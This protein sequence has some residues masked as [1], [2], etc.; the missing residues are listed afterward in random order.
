MDVFTYDKS[1][2]Y[3]FTQRDLN[4]HQRRW[5]ELLNDYDI[6]VH[7]HPGK[8][9]II[10]DAW[11]SMSMESTTNVDDEKKELSKDVHRLARLDVQLV[12]CTSVGVSVH[13]KE[14]QHLDPVLMEL[15][16]LVLIKMNESFALGGDSILRYQERLCVQ[17]VVDLRTVHTQ[18]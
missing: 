7:Y 11:S 18:F 9:N 14:G 15:K 12:D 6:N 1:L 3:V 2:Q 10:A 13:V 8:D 5:L 17:D 4:L 16:D